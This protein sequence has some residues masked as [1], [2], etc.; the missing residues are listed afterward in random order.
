MSDSAPS[1]SSRPRGQNDPGWNDPPKLEFSTVQA[2]NKTRLNLNKRVA[3]PLQGNSSAT[4]KP[5]AIVHP[6]HPPMCTPPVAIVPPMARSTAPAQPGADSISNESRLGSAA[7]DDTN[8]TDAERQ[9]CLDTFNSFVPR[10]QPGIN[11]RPDEVQWRIN[12][13][14]QMWL[15]GTLGPSVQRKIQSIAKA[16]AD[17]NFDEAIE[18]HRV[19]IV[20]HSN[21]C[22]AWGAALRQI[23]LTIQ[24]KSDNDVPEASQGEQHSTASG[25]GHHPSGSSQPENNAGEHSP[26][27]VQHL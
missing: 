22:M 16:L 6:S 27:R 24:P 26:S 14:N 4:S 12:L 23:I 20:E 15:N 25:D 19:L 9:L 5:T 13:M 3:F 10:V 7:G 2:G 1:R 11:L 18:K 17:N 21:L 8:L